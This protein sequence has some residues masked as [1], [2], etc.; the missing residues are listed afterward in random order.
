MRR[1]GIGTV[2]AY[3]V[4]MD[5]QL[6]LFLVLFPLLSA[7]GIAL[8]W[9]GLSGARKANE[10]AERE[11]T[12]AAGV[13]VDRVRHFSLG[14]G[15]P[16]MGWHPVVEFR[17]D[18]KTR[19]HESCAGYWS[20]QFSIGESVEILYDADDPSHFHLEEQFE[21]QA[22]ADRVTVIVGVLWIVVAGIVA[23]FVSR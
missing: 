17:V 13:V 19:R 18:G 11:R 8:L 16:L 15:K 7:G 3:E 9:I 23:Y 5:D 2:S 4:H 14:R 12:R 6:L 20:D 22:S 10:Q 1:R 21:R